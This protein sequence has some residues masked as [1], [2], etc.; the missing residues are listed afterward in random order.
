MTDATTS[1]ID[2]E[3]R[4]FWPSV[5]RGWKGRCPSCGQGP[6]LRGYLKVRDTCP[7]CGEAMHHHRADDGPAYLTILI[8]GYDM[9][10][11]RIM[12]TAQRALFGSHFPAGTLIPVPCLALPDMQ[13]EVEAI[14]VPDG[15][16]EAIRWKGPSYVFGMQWHPEFLAQSTFHEEQLDGGPIL[17]WSL[18]AR[19]ASPQQAARD[20]RAR[21]A[22]RRIRHHALDLGVPVGVLLVEHRLE[23]VG[24]RHVEAVEPVG[25]RAAV[26][27]VAVPAPA[28]PATA[29]VIA[30]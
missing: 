6:M 19:G 24:E 9:E 18:I 30:G 20:R 12:Q 21:E 27:A 11:L 2:T 23:Q 16:V 1:L 22:E 15:M 17:K 13:I 4:P 7:V 25:G 14:A 28:G 29:R 5:L 8:V 3:D 26:V 10:K